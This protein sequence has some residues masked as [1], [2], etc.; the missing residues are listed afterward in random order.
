M[1]EDP[2]LTQWLNGQAIFPTIRLGSEFDAYIKA[3][4]DRMA[5]VVKAT[6]A[7]GN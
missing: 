2:E 7:R 5:P 1:I 3:E 4:M 6:G